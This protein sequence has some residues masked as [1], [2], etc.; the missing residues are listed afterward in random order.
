[1]SEREVLIRVAD[2]KVGRAGVALITLG[3]GSC[4]AILLFDPGE[5]IG[6]LAHIMLPSRSAAGRQRDNPATFPQT[7]VPAVLAEM[8]LLGADRR[9]INARLVG[10]A[11]MFA[12]LAPPGTIQMGERNLAS[13]R[14]VLHHQGIP[15]IGEAVGG[16]FGR[17]V[18]FSVESGV[19]QIRSV[20][21]GEQR[22]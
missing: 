14:E 7:A 10:G 20:A 13:C 4:V 6:G 17:S 12:S 5:K 19:V 1:M 3:L 18:R 2:F 9:R 8:G 15:V 21:H 16:D 11:S 22:L